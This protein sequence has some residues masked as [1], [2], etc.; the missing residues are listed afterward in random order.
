MFLLHAKEFKNEKGQAF[1]ALQIPN[2]DGDT[3]G[4]A[5]KH[6]KKYLGSR[7]QSQLFRLLFSNTVN[8]A[9]G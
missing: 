4:G 1:G 2:K 5:A 6:L 8:P 7:S 9:S 3:P